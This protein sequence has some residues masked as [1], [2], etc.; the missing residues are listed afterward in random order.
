MILSVTDIFLQLDAKLYYRNTKGQQTNFDPEMAA[1]ALTFDLNTVAV[2][3]END[4]PPTR[5]MPSAC[6]GLI[7]VLDCCI[8][9]LRVDIIPA[10]MHYFRQKN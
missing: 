9:L 1:L 3:I 8:M 2:S 6:H 5:Y 7:K 4:L 10:L